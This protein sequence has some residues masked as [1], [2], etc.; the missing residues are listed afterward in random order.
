VQPQVSDR[1]T[2]LCARHENMKL[3]I[4]KMHRVGLINEKDPN[5]VCKAV[6]CDVTSKKCMYGE[7]EQCQD[8]VLPETKNETLQDVNSFYNRWVTKTEQRKRATDGVEIKVKVMSNMK[9]EAKSTDMISTFQVE[10]PDFKQHH[11]RAYHQQAQLAA[12]RAKLS[13]NECVLV[14]D[15]SENYL[16][17]YASETQSVHFGALRRQ[18]TLHTGVLYYR[19]RA[20]EL[21]CES[22]CTISESLR[23]GFT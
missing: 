13:C 19:N 2:C 23:H 6:V 20:N 12:L 11:Y 4:W 3:L 22:F 21:I 5:K 15:Y 18:L 9:V 1:Q 8:K 17:K 14:I 7:C 16:C 10:L